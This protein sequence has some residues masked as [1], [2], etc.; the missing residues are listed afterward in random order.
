MPES[1]PTK[2][3][4]DRFILQYIDSVPQLEALLLAWESRPR[5]WTLN[6]AVLAFS[7]ARLAVHRWHPG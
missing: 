5:Q 2:E 1:D 3:E 7:V 4:V 6:S